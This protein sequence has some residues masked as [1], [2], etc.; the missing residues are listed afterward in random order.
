MSLKNSDIESKNINYFQVFAYFVTITVVAFIITYLLSPGWQYYKFTH[1]V[2]ESLGILIAISIFAFIWSISSI[3]KATLLLGY[4]FFSASI[5]HT[6]HIVFWHKY[7]VFQSNYFVL[8]TLFWLT[9]RF[10]EAF[11]L[12]INTL[13]AKKI[14]IS[15]WLGLGLALAASLFLVAFLYLM[16][17]AYYV[18]TENAL[19]IISIIIGNAIIILFI[20]FLVRLL[21]GFPQPAIM[22]KK[23]LL[24][25][26]LFAVPAELCF[27]YCLYSND[28]FHLLGNFLKVCYYF[29]L[30]KAVVYSFIIFPY[31]MIQASE[32]RFY[33]IFHY[34]PTMES[35]ISIRDKRFIDVNN[36]WLQVTGY[37]KEE[38][39]GKTIQEMGLYSEEA[40]EEFKKEFEAGGGKLRNKRFDFKTKSGE[41]RKAMISAQEIMLNN[42]PCILNV[43]VDITSQVHHEQ[44]MQRLDKLKLINEIA[45]SIGHEVRNP[46]TSVRGF[47]Q[48]MSTKSKYQEDRQYFNL[49]IS[50]LDRANTIITEFLSLTKNTSSD[51]QL[52]NLGDL[53]DNVSPLLQADASIMGKHVIIENQPTPDI[54]VNEKEMN[55]LIMNLVRNGLEA[56][57]QCGCVT[58]KTY[59]ENESVVLA[60]EDQGPGIDPSIINKLGTPFVTTKDD[61]TGLG[62]AICYSIAERH[63]AKLEFETGPEGTTFF[64]KFKIDN[65]EAGIF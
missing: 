5:L 42:E 14:S 28:Y 40:I 2:L 35:I 20:I 62:L 13:P 1:I 37:N 34:S 9:G 11:F 29:F 10:I 51:R 64:V 12:L 39:I 16:H 50:E 45:A 52:A 27:T 60:V 61:G 41:I 31:K 15:R 33:K 55:Q 58:V 7:V 56:M 30:L 4:G 47:L 21:K 54:K 65:N 38:V 25:A 36:V 63:G 3:R 44:E 19:P 53:V 48:L 22:L 32:E 17:Q 6:A 8:S 46:M 26:I 57:E 59:V 43:I 24:L 49:M 18:F 23:D